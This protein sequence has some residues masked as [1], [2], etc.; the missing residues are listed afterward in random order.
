MAL[1]IEAS[2]L[3][4]YLEAACTIDAT[5]EKDD[6]NES[7]TILPGNRGRKTVLIANN[8]KRK[9]DSNYYSCIPKTQLD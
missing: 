6:S 7:W 2:K 1:A 5:P 9:L 4:A 3:T 8:P